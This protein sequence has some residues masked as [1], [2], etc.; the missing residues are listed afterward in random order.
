MS[1]EGS[2]ENHGNADANP[3]GFHFGFGVSVTACKARSLSIYNSR[4]RSA[5]GRVP[6]RIKISR[7]LT[8]APLFILVPTFD[9]SATCGWFGF[10][11]STAATFDVFHSFQVTNYG[12]PYIPFDSAPGG[13]DC[14]DVWD[15]LH[16][17]TAP[18]LFRATFLATS[19]G[20]S[21]LKSCLRAQR[22]HF[23]FELTRKSGP[24]E[25]W[26]KA[27]T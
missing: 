4:A 6:S 25:N 27:P 23:E 15:L 9:P 5:A 1:C 7:I 21:K 26:A 10:A 8:T 11:L 3:D 2:R 12:L 14:I 22:T 18:Q 20:E 16:A 24:V 13:S 19:P 17:Q